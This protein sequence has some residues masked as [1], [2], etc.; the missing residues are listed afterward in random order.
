V[1]ELE[2]DYDEPV[3]W[4]DCACGARIVRRVNEEER[5]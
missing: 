2:A 1:R 3:I 5:R 4:M